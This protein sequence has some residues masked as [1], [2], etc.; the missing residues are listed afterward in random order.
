MPRQNETGARPGEDRSNPGPPGQGRRSLGRRPSDE[1][2]PSR[3][4]PNGFSLVEA[5][6]AALVLLLAAGGLVRAVSASSA[7]GRAAAHTGLATALARTRLDELHAAPLSK[8]WPLSG[9]HDAV[10]PGGSADPAG[11]GT[12][13]YVAFFGE[14]GEPASPDAALYEVRWSIRELTSAGSDRLRSL[15]FEVLAMPSARGRGP[16]VRLVS[17]RVANGA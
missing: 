14:R 1:R 15:R 2:K 8:P 3:S 4:G 12:P 9:Y 16:V 10:A 6:L 11:A 13:G 5:L 17:V 7:A